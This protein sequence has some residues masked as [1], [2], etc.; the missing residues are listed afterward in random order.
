MALLLL[1]VDGQTGRGGLKPNMELE[2]N[3]DMDWAP[4]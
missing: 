3:L 2:L 4:G 1:M